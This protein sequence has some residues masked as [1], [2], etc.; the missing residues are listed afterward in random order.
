MKV[1]SPRF[2]APSTAGDAIGYPRVLP[3]TPEARIESE[4]VQ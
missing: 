3:L 4:G 2:D 1:D